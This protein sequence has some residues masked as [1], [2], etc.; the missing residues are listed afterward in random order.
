VIFYRPIEDGAEI[1][2]IL[3]G[4]R[5]LGAIFRPDEES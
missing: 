1:L 2:R 4:S 5:D 3:H